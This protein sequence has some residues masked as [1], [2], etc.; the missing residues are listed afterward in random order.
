ML[1][2]RARHRRSFG[3]STRTILLQ[4]TLSWCAESASPSNASE[5]SPCSVKFEPKFLLIF[6]DYRLLI[7]QSNTSILLKW[8]NSNDAHFAGTNEKIKTTTIF[9]IHFHHCFS[10][11]VWGVLLE[12]PEGNC[13]FI[14]PVWW[15]DLYKDPRWRVSARK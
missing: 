10:D 2:A 14:D 7:I 12:R 5:H 3:L 9:L 8:P 1:I 15:I 11:N 13:E 6:M 4:R